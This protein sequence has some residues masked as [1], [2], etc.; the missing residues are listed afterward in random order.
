MRYCS[1]H[2]KEYFADCPVC[3]ALSREAADPKPTLRQLENVRMAAESVY[4]D[5]HLIFSDPPALNRKIIRLGMMLKIA[6]GQIKEVEQVN[7]RQTFFRG[8]LSAP[9]I[10]DEKGRCCGR[11]P[12]TYKREGHRF[13]DRCSRAYHLYNN[14][15]IDNWAWKQLRPSGQFEYITG[16]SRIGR[17]M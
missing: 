1:Q 14:H 9:M 8:D 12:L 5:R 10:L 16:R 7:E 3:L 11:K 6:A 4:Q 13:C 17:A 2:Q 15:Q